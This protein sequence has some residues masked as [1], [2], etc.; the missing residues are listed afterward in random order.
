MSSQK[1]PSQELPLF[2]PDATRL[3]TA[4]DSSNLPPEIASAIRIVSGDGI[5]D[6]ASIFGGVKEPDQPKESARDRWEGGLLKKHEAEKAKPEFHDYEFH[7][8]DLS[9]QEDRAKMAE[10]FNRVS[11]PGS[12]HQIEQEPVRIIGD[13]RAPKGF[14]AITI[15][16]V[17]KIK[18]TIP[19]GVVPPS[20]A[21]PADKPS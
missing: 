4:D 8:L 1:D 2:S 20:F 15:V 13:S 17:W 11:V 10:I 21:H 3:G 5:D 16:K 6:M 7:C 19:E 18:M 14:R 9:D 12:K